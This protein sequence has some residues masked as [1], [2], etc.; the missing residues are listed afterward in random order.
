MTKWFYIKLGLL[1]GAL[2]A[3]TYTGHFLIFHDAHHIFIYL[4]GDLGFMFL[5][6]L[7]IT[8]I[9]HELLTRREKK[10]MLEAEGETKPAINKLKA[11]INSVDAQSGKKISEEDARLLIE[12]AENSIS[13]L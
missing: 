9:L 10:M 5:E 2:S 3:V 13:G 4:V 8:L 7:L 6:V 11:F 1:L 12:F